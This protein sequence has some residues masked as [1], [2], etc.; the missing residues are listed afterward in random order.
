[1]KLLMI[2]ILIVSICVVNA[3]STN[4]VPKTEFEFANRLA[5]NDLWKEAHFRWSKLLEIGKESAALYNNIAVA[6][7]KM[8]QFE[9]AEQA[10][11]KAMKL[12]PNNSTIKSNYDK[13]KRMLKQDKDKNEKNKKKKDKE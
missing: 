5:Q 13:F 4:P 2:P 11:Q 1:M 8:G 3:C 7:E 9:E 6:Y 10:Y 12:S